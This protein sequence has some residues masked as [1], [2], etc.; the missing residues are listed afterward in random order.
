MN[1]PILIPAFQPGSQLPALV[2]QLVQRAVSLIVIVDNASGPDY[3][4][5]FE[6]CSA[7]PQVR[8][9]RHPANLGKGASLKTGIRYV[10]ESFPDSGGVVTADADGQHDPD[11]IVA[12]AQALARNPECLVIGCR[13][14]DRQVPLRSRVGN[15]LTRA[16]S[17]VILGQRV[18]DSQTGLRGLP[19]KVLA[20]F[21]DLPSNGYEF[22]LEMLIAAKHLGLTIV[23]QRIRTIY[24]PGNPTSHFDP[25]RDSLK[26]YRVLF[27]FSLLWLLTTALDCLAFYFAYHTAASVLAA[28]VIGRSAA[29]LFNY[30]PARKAAFLSRERHGV[31]IPRYILVAVASAGA[32]YGLIRLL[33]NFF[34]MDPIRAKII[35]E[36]LLFAVNFILMRDFVFTGR[37]RAGAT[38]WTRY[39]GSL[40]FTARLSR[41]YTAGVLMAELRKHRSDDIGGVI[42]ELGGANSCFLD[43]II[44]ELRPSAYHV[45]DNND[46]GLNILSQRPDKPPQVCLHR[47]NVLNMDLDVRAGAVFSVRLI[48]HFDPPGTRKAV[49]KHLELLRPGG[50]AILSF[51]TPTALYRAAR[52]VAEFAGLWNFPDERPIR[53]GEVLES[54]APFAQV[55]ITRTLWPLVFTQHLIVVRKREV[56]REAA[57]SV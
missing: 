28:Q 51:R 54:L 3:A 56:P 48:E 1:T 50:Y 11:D 20:D 24:E 9:L 26:I 43:R 44:A 49:L 42:V 8:I 2:E 30:S 47:G 37:T 19:V 23:E 5:V 15:R 53:P 41:E 22:E 36:S 33:A 55:V 14:F 34:G 13:Q 4:G 21:L 39:H 46:H 52:A 25:L 38:D 32:S 35:A 45:V 10:L 40:P 6:S 31:L 17:R 57:A 29:G 12:V 27:R 7:F 18:Q 16:L